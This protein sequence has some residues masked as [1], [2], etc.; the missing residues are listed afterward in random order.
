MGASLR[1]GVAS[2]PPGCDAVLVLLGDQVGVNA[3]DLK[4]LAAAWKGEESLIAAS[5]YDQRVG[6]PAIFPRLCFSELAELRG[7][8]GARAVLE[9][10]S[11][12]ADPRAH[13]ERCDRSRHAGGSRRAHRTLQ[14]AAAGITGCVSPCCCSSSPSSS[15]S[16][17]CGRDASAESSVLMA[18]WL[19]PWFAVFALFS[20]HAAGAQPTSELYALDRL[21][22][23][24]EF[25]GVHGLAF[26]SHDRLYAGSVV[27]HSIYAVDSTNGRVS[28][29]VG[30]PEG[31]ADDLVFLA[32][33]TV[34]WTSIQHGV[35]RARTGDGPVRKI[36]DLVSVNS[37]NVRKDGRLFA[38]QVF[39]GD[40]L[41]GDRSGRRE[42]AGLI[43]KD[44]GGFNGFDIGPDGMLYGPLWF[45]HQVVRIDPDSGALKVI[46]DGFDTPA[47]ANFDSSGTS[48][49]L[50]TARGEVVRVDIRSG[51]KQ[52]AREAFDC[53]R[54]PRARLARPHV[55]LEHGGQRHP[56]GRC[57]HGRGAP[58]DQGRARD[59]A[60]HRLGDRRSA[61]HALRCRRVRATHR[62]SEPGQGHR[63]RARARGRHTD[64][65]SRRDH[66]KPAPCHRHEQR[67]S[68]AALR[69]QHDAPG[70]ELGRHACGQRYRAALGRSDRRRDDPR[71]AR[72][73]SAASSARRSSPVSLRRSVSR[74]RAT[75]PST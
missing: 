66:G 40:A 69:P 65:L 70:A 59:P 62:R 53:A 5:M 25:H 16:S 39:G 38:A 37:I 31:M 4:R 61:R 11:L 8:Q 24:S 6:V 45:K 21:V 44:L 63:H 2:L 50:D 18:R 20:W 27:G 49:V 42:A 47:A 30:A 68:G 14:S 57:A 74:S 56:G 43:L 72:A 33:D 9:R 41:V 48:Y 64:R 67:R 22:P 46:A 28:S 51:Q 55:R 35:V 15:W 58:G 71:Q 26:D 36:A 12:P 23:P 1:F 34:V 17:G 60:R 75:T 3:D 29:F 73:G 19:S 13:V 54:Q 32:D 7:D 52:V 10:N